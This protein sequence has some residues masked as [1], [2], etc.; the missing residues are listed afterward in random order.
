MVQ[1]NP[2]RSSV[3]SELPSYESLNP[4]NDDEDPPPPLTPMTLTA[5][6]VPVALALPQIEPARGGAIPSVI[7]GDYT[8]LSEGSTRAAG[9]ARNLPRARAGAIESRDGHIDTSSQQDLQYVLHYLIG[10]TLN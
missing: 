1:A 6:G 2:S 5:G 9:G 4:E 7:G 8:R 3:Y 10:N